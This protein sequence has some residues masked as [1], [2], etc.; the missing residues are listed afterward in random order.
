MD[1]EGL[2]RNGGDGGTHEP[3][4]R[5]MISARDHGIA[6][7]S[8]LDAPHTVIIVSSGLMTRT[9]LTD[10]TSVT[11]GSYRIYEEN[12]TSTE[13]VRSRDLMIFIG[14]M[15]HKDDDIVRNITEMKNGDEVT[16]FSTYVSPSISH[17]LVI[18]GE[19]IVRTRVAE[20]CVTLS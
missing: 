9:A 17:P 1:P 2:V 18:Y 19:S 20:V 5:G 7:G 4:K 12:E 14:P 8:E 15:T 6:T 3:V 11:L 10:Q 13:V 16:R